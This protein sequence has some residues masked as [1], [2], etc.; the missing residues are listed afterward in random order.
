M[1]GGAGGGGRG[2]AG[3][4]GL[5]GIGAGVAAGVLYPCP[6][7][8]PNEGDACPN[9]SVTCT[10]PSRKS[11][12]CYSKVWRCNDCPASQPAPTDSCSNSFFRLSLSCSYGNVTCACERRATSPW[13]CGT[14]PSSEPLTGDLC[15]NLPAGECRYGADTCTCLSNGTWS[16]TTATCPANPVFALTRTSC[17]SPHS[18]YTCQYADQDCICLPDSTG[19]LASNCSCPANLPVEGN[20]C[21]SVVPNCVYG[22]VSCACAGTWQCENTTPP[23]PCPTNQP[24][25]GAACSVRVSTCAFGSAI[26]A[27]DGTS[28]SCSP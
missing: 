21:L 3:S 9:D 26:C 17:T 7:P 19:A 13:R 20:A 6:E 1:T 22:D 23:N 15:G 16:C 10:Y 18:T 8:P 24:T 4:P 2:G 11:C 5:A 14:C 25:R 27:C 28:W 12:A